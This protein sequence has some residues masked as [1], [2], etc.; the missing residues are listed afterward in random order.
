MEQEENEKQEYRAV[1]NEIR[2]C[3][4]RLAEVAER[5]GPYFSR[6]E[7]RQRAI[8]YIKGLLSTV[9][10]KNGWQL[11]EDAGDS[12]PYAIQHLL[13][14]SEWDA[15]LIRDELCQYVNE[16]LADR[17]GVLVVDETGFLKKGDKSAGVQRQYSGTAGRVE[18]C[19]IGVFLAYAGSKGR[20]F[21]DRELYLPKSWATNEA[22]RKE[23]GIPE[24]IK[25]ATKIEIARSMLERAF[26]AGVVTKW[27]TADAVYG[28]DHP[29]R[30]WMENRK[31]A[32]L[33]GVTSQEHLW[34]NFKKVD[35]KTIIERLSAKSWHRLS[36]G[37]GAKGP[38][39]YD[40][41]KFSFKS[42]SAGWKHWFLARRSISEPAQID[43]YVVFA[44]SNTSLQ[45]MVRVAGTRWAIEESFQSAKG[46]VGLD[47]YEVRLWQGWYRHIT[48]ALW[49]HAF[50]TLM[51]ANAIAIDLKKRLKTADQKSSLKEFKTM[52]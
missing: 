36:A 49:A 16:H 23:A 34:I 35:V 50:L 45:E 27:V 52:R 7:P 38:R 40:W 13:G 30:R 14:R 51:R 1:R 33:L 32:F 6:E 48:L 5:I 29:L 24:E 8:T 47:Q 31:Q 43:Y 12:T 10:R 15:D 44:P 25:F 4:K 18:N 17:E 46:E 9:E 19:Q 37:D 20:T 26:N 42:S 11:A 41:A 28:S 2:N 39:I 3:A 21:I 22:R